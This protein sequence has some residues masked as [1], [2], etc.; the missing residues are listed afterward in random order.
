MIIFISI[1][2]TSWNGEKRVKPHS[3]FILAPL[4]CFLLATQSYVMAIQSILSYF[5]KEY[6]TVGKTS[7]HLKSSRDGTIWLKKLL[8]VVEI[9]KN[10]LKI[11]SR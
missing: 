9:I 11:I 10:L 3:F 1:T 4:G 7:G 6:E 8:K 5:I 2:E